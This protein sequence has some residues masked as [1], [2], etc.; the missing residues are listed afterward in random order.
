[1]TKQQTKQVTDTDFGIHQY[2]VNGDVCSTCQQLLCKDV[3]KCETKQKTIDKI[4]E[5]LRRSMGGT[6]YTGPHPYSKEEYAKMIY[7]EII[8][9]KGG[10]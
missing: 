6:S 9:K 4:V 8:E 1:M 10:E 3:C 7:R 2:S 5:I